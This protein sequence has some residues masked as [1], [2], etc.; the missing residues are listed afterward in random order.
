MNMCN[1][2]VVVF[3]ELGCYVQQ[4]FSLFSPYHE[5]MCILSP[6]CNFVGHLIEQKFN[7]YDITMFL[8]LLI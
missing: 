3:G 4:Y 2:L 5:N 8:F 6:M 1:C 7:Y